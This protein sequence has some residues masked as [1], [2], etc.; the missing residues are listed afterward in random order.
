MQSPYGPPD[1]GAGGAS[2]PYRP[3]ATTTSPYA[4]GGPL[5]PWPRSRRRRPAR[6]K[7]LELQW[8]PPLSPSWAAASIQGEDGRTAFQM[9]A[10]EVEAR[11]PRIF[12]GEMAMAATRVQRVERGIQCRSR[13]W[14]VDLPGGATYT[15]LALV[16]ASSNP[17]S[18]HMSTLA[19]H[20]ARKGQ[21]RWRGVL[22][23]RKAVRRA[24]AYVYRAATLMAAVCRGGA[25]RRLARAM[26]AAVFETAAWR[27]QRAFRDKMVRKMLAEARRLRRARMRGRMQRCWRMALG[28]RRAARFAVA[29]AVAAARLDALS[30]AARLA[31]AQKERNK[32]E[33][34]PEDAL[35]GPWEDVRDP[36]GRVVAFKACSLLPFAWE[37]ASLIGGDEYEKPEEKTAEAP[38]DEALDPLAAYKA[39]KAAAELR[40]TQREGPARGVS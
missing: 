39:R 38:V 5:P 37:V 29:S 2:S 3:G 7:N 31:R 23:R 9:I 20:W 36:V 33:L 21:K 13:L 30:A 40:T 6:G 34:P 15:R 32:L 8:L 1:P 35:P 18:I 11:P 27:V 16:A 26:R 14:C 12:L 17:P 28:K 4:A 22:G 10:D 19:H 25:A 24:E